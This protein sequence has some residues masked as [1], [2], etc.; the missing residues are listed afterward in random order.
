MDLLHGRCKPSPHIGEGRRLISWSQIA[1]YITQRVL[2]ATFCIATNTEKIGRFNREQ[3]NCHQQHLI[4]C[5]ILRNSSA[6]K[7]HA[8]KGH[9]PS[10]EETTTTISWLKGKCK[11]RFASGRQSTCPAN[12]CMLAHMHRH[13]LYILFSI[14]IILLCI[15][16]MRRTHFVGDKKE[17][18]RLKAWANIHI[19]V[20]AESM[21][22]CMTSIHKIINNQPTSL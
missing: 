13:S 14:L 17:L 10:A 11:M 4:T 19:S 12:S 20:R 18:K 2:L 1:S 6:L 16:S 3:K 21:R 22:K 7:E 15:H 5:V 8:Y 9:V